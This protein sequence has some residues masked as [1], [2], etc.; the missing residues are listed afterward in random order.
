[1]HPVSHEDL[2]ANV[3]DVKSELKHFQ[4]RF[5]EHA[6][7]SRENRR[8]VANELHEIRTRLEGGSAMFSEVK[9]IVARVE[10]AL[11]ALS[12][13]HGKQEATLGKVDDRVAQLE[14]TDTAHKAERGLLASFIGSPFFGWLAAGIAAMWAFLKHSGAEA[15]K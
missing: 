8:Q 2:W 13:D 7:L 14:R 6:H 9:T 5:D 3:A 12:R 4:L 11:T 10:M 1:M 15:I